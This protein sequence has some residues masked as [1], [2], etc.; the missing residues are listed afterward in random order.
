MCLQLRVPAYWADRFDGW[1]HLGGKL[2][3]CCFVFAACVIHVVV[4]DEVI[5]A[6]L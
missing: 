6:T 3:R 5:T 4:V 2:Q 1:R